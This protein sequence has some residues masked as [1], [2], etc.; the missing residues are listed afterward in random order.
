MSRTISYFDFA[1]G[2]G[3]DCRIA[4]HI[5]GVE[6]TDDRVTDWPARKAT[7]PFGALPTY[8]EDGRRL[9]QSNA[10]LTYLGRTHG[11]HPTDLWQAAEHEAVMESVEDFRAKMPSSKDPEEKK[12]LRE[13]FAAGWL[14]TWASSVASHIRGPFLA[15]DTLSVADLKLYVI[16]KAIR[17]GTYDHVTAD[18]LA[19]AP[20]LM[21]LFEAVHAHPGVVSWYAR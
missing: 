19:H 21:T 13:A 16:L 17:G 15:G 12:A 5:A 3:E 18:H 20:A 8:E 10:I 7:T 6:F 11:L 4:L 1:G 9:A 14:Q 2:R